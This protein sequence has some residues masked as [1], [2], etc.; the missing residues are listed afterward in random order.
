[1][2][3]QTFIKNGR[4]TKDA[5]TSKLIGM[6]FPDLMRYLCEMA[7][8]S[9]M[10]RGHHVDHIFPLARFGEHEEHK[11][12][13]YSNLQLLT[14]KENQSKSARLPTKDMAAR[15]HRDRWRDE[16]TE[17]SMLPDIYPGWRTPLRM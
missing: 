15:V 3:L 4:F 8:V 13:H 2:R 11:M 12:M 5:S 14:S 16:I 9:E 1:M 10:T 17:D 6:S 7:G